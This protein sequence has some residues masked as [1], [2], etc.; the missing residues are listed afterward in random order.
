MKEIP[1]R[2]YTGNYEKQWYEVRLPNGEIHLCWPNAGK[3]NTMD[4]TGKQWSV[5]DG[6]EYRETDRHPLTEYIAKKRIA[7]E[8]S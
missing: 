4:G 5:G 2:P 1:F 6:I 8:R 3:M 7:D